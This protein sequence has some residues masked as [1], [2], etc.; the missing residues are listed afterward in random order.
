VRDNVF[1]TSQ[2]RRLRQFRELPDLPFSSLL[3]GRRVLFSKIDCLK[4]K[5]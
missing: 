5:A 1:T 2:Q 4:R 3:V